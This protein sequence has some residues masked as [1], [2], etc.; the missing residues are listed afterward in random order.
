MTITVYSTPACHNCALAKEFLKNQGFQ[1]SEKNV[2]ADPVALE[3]MLTQSGQM[4]VPVI[5][6]DNEMIV[7][8]DR[9][10][11]KKKLGL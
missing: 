7:G 9:N 8:F 10:E 3:W 11:M 5:E 2:A 6:I 1:Y 4:G